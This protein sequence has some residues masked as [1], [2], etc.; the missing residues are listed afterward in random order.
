MTVQIND[1]VRSGMLD[2]I[3]TG[4]GITGS[5]KVFTGAQPAA[6]T[7]ANSGT[8]LVTI[9]LPAD[10]MNA[11]ASGAMTLKGV[12]SGTAGAGAA[13]TPGHFRVYTSQVTMDGTTCFAQGSCAVGGGDL[14][15]DGTITSGQTVTISTF[16]LTEGS[17]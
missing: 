17:S 7:D 4:G 16:T 14:S 15:F 6:T 13:S 11:A 8:D 12:W 2:A 5:M 1:A 9:N 10:W 3:E